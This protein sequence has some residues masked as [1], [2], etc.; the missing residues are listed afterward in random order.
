MGLGMSSNGIKCSVL[1]QDAERYR[2]STYIQHNDVKFM[3]CMEFNTTE[4]LIQNML[5]ILKSLS[6]LLL[7]QNA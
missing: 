6:K 4:T 7:M 3:W 5:P 2:K 1:E